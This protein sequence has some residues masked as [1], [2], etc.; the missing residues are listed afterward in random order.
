MST[1]RFA[2]KEWAVICRALAEGRQTILLRKGGVAEKTGAFE[3]E[4]ERFWLYPTYVHQQGA[5]VVEEALPLLKAVEAERPPAGVV[6]L[7]HFAEVAGVFHLHDIVGALRLDGL[8]L[9]SRETVL[10]RFEYRVP[11]LFALVVRVYRA[12]RPTEL[13]ETAEYAGCRSWVDLGRD[14]PTDGATPVLE[15]RLFYEVLHEMERRLEP[16]AWV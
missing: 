3:V 1:L 8:H 12:A 4:Q 10:S 13:P 6:R 15:D 14:L 2:L 7:S 9:W 5:G 11:G 16:R